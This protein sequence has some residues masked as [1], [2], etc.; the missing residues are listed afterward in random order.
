VGVIVNAINGSIFLLINALRPEITAQG[1]G[2]I[3]FLVGGIQTNTAPGQVAAAALICALVFVVLMFL[4][5]SL[6]VAGLSEAE[7]QSLGV[8][9]HRLRWVA[10]VLASV[11][12][13]AAVAISGPIGFVGLICP[14]LARR[15]VGHDA[16]R[17]LPLSA[18]MGA[19]LLA[20]ADA[21]SRGMIKIAGTYPPV[22]V[23]TGLLG[24][25]FFLYLLYR[26][27]NGSS[28]E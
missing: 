27:R 21:L 12:T 8:R 11:M 14:H 28:A 16:R 15:L 4:A 10:L 19:G 13:A 20:L 23:I 7:A 2:T 3:G 24:G 18:A 26:Q 25:P 17:L 22:G 1:G 6:N 9:I 5:A